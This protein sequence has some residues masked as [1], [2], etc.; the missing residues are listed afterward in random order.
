MKSYIFK[1][2][3]PQDHEEIPLYPNDF[4]H[5]HYSMPKDIS[6]PENPT[7]TAAHIVHIYLETISS[8]YRQILGYLK[9]GLLTISPSGETIVQLS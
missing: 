8:N 4:L 5:A 2:L 1:I 3:T 7:P 9:N 6:M